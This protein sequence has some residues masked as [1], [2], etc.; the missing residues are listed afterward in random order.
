MAIYILK[1]D[2]PIGNPDKKYGTASYY[3]G[4][5]ADTRI[6]ERFAEHKAG[7]GAALTR[8]AVQQ[9]IGFQIVVT[10]PGDRAKERQLKRQ[11][12]TR[13]IVERHLKSIAGGASCR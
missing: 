10:M 1:F 7:R 13:R 11:K 6:A 2:R 3:I 4:Y 8:A 12:N 5:C 9:G